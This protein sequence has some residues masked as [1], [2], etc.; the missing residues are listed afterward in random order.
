[1][2]CLWA[3]H[4]LSRPL[5]RSGQPQDRKEDPKRGLTCRHTE[6]LLL[7]GDA[8]P[9]DARGLAGQQHLLLGHRPDHTGQWLHHRGGCKGT[10]QQRS[11]GT[12][13][14]GGGGGLSTREK[15]SK[16]NRGLRKPRNRGHRQAESFLPENPLALHLLP[17]SRARLSG[18]GTLTLHSEDHVLV[19]HAC[20]VAGRAGVAASVDGEGLPDF[21]GP[22]GWEW[23]TERD[24]GTQN[25]HP[26]EE[27]T[28]ALTHP[29][30]VSLLRATQPA[31]PPICKENGRTWACL[32]PCP[33]RNMGRS[34]PLSASSSLW[35]RC[36]M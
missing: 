35:A 21:Q 13:P 27:A 19:G 3:G 29:T 30:L 16:G 9:R 5:C 17:A 10:G 1:M 15:A 7:P 8:R 32:S 6:P 33:E 25:G 11:L 28:W 4:G 31:S 20:S 23:G 26:R 22:C 34:L 14:T 24:E 18:P 2:P 36:T 12:P